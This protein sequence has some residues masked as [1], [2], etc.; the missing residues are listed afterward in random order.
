L[1]ITVSISWKPSGRLPYKQTDVY[2]GRSPHQQ[3][4][5]IPDDLSFTTHLLPMSQGATI[6]NDLLT[7]CLIILILAE[8]ST[9]I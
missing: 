4:V 6:F 3:A 2:F 1:A 8:N 9:A 7:S 5:V